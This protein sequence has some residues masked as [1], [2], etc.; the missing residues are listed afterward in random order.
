MHDGRGGESRE[1][2]AIVDLTF[3][4]CVVGR[5]EGHENDFEIDAFVFEKSAVVSCV[6]R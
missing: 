6:D 4:E 3:E 5:A 1:S 2:R